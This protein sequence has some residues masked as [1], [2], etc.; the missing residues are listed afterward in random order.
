MLCRIMLALL[1]AVAVA[2][3]AANAEPKPDEEGSFKAALGDNGLVALEFKGTQLLKNGDLAVTGAFFQKPNGDVYGADLARGRLA[4]NGNTFTLGYPWGSVTAQYTL[5]P[6]RLNAKVAIE[7]AED[8]DTLVALYIQFA[9]LRFPKTPSITN[10]SWL[11]YTKSNMAHN[12]GG[13]G[14]LAAEFDDILLALCNEQFVRPL[15]FG[16]GDPTDKEKLCYPVLA[17]T[18]RH[19]MA[20]ERFPWIDRPIHAGGRDTLSLSIRFGA[21][22]NLDDMTDDLYQNY[23]RTYPYELK[24]EDRRPIGRLFLSSSPRKD[25]P[26]ATNPRGWFNSADVDTTTEEGRARFR[27]RLLAYADNSIKIMKEMNAQGMVVWDIEG[28]EN[29]HMISYL[30]DPRSLPPE[31]EPVADEFFQKFRE[32]GFRTGITIRPQRPVRTAYGDK[33]FQQDFTDRRAR[34]ANLCEKIDVARKRWGATLFYMDSDVDWFGDP[35]SIP[36]APGY[37]AAK[38]SQ[39]MRDL[40]LKYPDCLFMPEWEDLR[41]YAYS[42]PYTQLNYNKLVMPPPYVLRAYP[43][44]FFANIAVTPEIEQQ[45]AA[46]VDSVRHGC[47]LYFDGWWGAPH[48]KFV[49]DIYEEATKA[50]L[51]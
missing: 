45:Q 15:A 9:E 13:P 37:T 19:P 40:M 23:A 38:D 1:C 11:F 7:L 25:F 34:F 29:P 21:A 39:L 32:A 42:A 4:R 47:I 2:S 36:G 8:A 50:P 41:T 5:T 22:A 17:Y 26:P 35:V 16:L 28:Q 46:L 33:V 14:V 30:G 48:N 27:E 44:A 20:R 43:K 18:G 31:M 6:D 51:P 10:R 24:W 49:K 12:V 3:C